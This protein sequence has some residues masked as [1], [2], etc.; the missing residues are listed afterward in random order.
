M[1]SPCRTDD[2]LWPSTNSE[3]LVFWEEPTFTSVL[4]ADFSCWQD[5]SSPTA[6]L[7]TPA[8]P[9]N[10]PDHEIPDLNTLLPDATDNATITQ[11]TPNQICTINEKELFEILDDTDPAIWMMS[12]QFDTDNKPDQD[13]LDFLFTEDTPTPSP[14]TS[15]QKPQVTLPLTQMIQMPSSSS[16]QLKIIQTDRTIL[17]T[18]MKAKSKTPAPRTQRGMAS[19]SSAVTNRQRC[20]KHR[21]KKKIQKQKEAEEYKELIRRNQELKIHAAYFQSEITKMNEEMRTLGWI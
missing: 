19:F 21:Q 15:T 14:T 8:N 1:V 2:D 3:S 13:M 7:S 9:S 6:Q 11:I 12:P 4:P 17:K 20:A 18:T 10:V 16:I 5:L